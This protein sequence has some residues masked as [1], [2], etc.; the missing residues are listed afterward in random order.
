MKPLPTTKAIRMSLVANP[1][2]AVKHNL[3]ILHGLVKRRLARSLTLINQGNAHIRVGQLGAPMYQLT[4]VHAFSETISRC[5]RPLQTHATARQ[6]PTCLDSATDF[7]VLISLRSAAEA[8][9]TT[10]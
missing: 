10:Y 1:A 6:Q 2:N 9:I 8:Q 4:T 7:P 3:T 5:K